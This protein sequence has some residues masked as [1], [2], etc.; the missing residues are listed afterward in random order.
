MET[1]CSLVGQRNGSRPRL[2]RLTQALDAE[3]RARI[4]AE[5][6]ARTL[7]LTVRRL[8]ATRDAKAAE[9]EPSVG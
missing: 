7:R 9:V 4:T 5:R 6:K 2:I 1:C 3:R 8:L